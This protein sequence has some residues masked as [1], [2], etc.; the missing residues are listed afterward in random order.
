MRREVRLG[1]MLLALAAGLMLCAAFA[2]AQQGG[3]G[4]AQETLTLKAERKIEFTTDEGTWISVDVSPDGQTIVFDL[5]GDLYTLPISGG[6]AK[7]L[8]TG[9][10]FDSQPKFSPDGKWIA[11]LSDRSGGEN[12]W[13]MKADGTEP[14]QL[15]R[16][17]DSEFASPVWT[18]DGQY[19]V[20]AR[21]TWP[22]RVHELWMYHI[23]G[24][25]G[26]QLTRAT[27]AG[28]AA[29]G[30]PTPGPGGQPPRTN[31]IGA[32]FSPDGRYL[33]FSRKINGFQYNAMFPLWQIVRHD[34]VTGE[35]DTL[36][37]AE[38]SAMRPL[39]SPDGTKMV[40]ATRYETQTGLRIRDLKTGEERWLKY[41]VQRDDQESRY[42]MDLM[43]GYAFLPDGK[44]LLLTYGGKIHRLDVATGADPVIPFTAKVAQEL[45]PK[46]DF[47]YRVDQ[48]PVRARL[49]QSP[50][51]SPDGS[52]LAFS[53]LTH[54]YVMDLPANC[55][56]P[57]RGTPRR[58]TSGNAREYQPA[59]S[60]DGRWIAYVT[61]DNGQGGIWKIAADGSGAPQQLT[62]VPEFYSDP[63]WSPDGRRIV[64]M[65]MPAQARED[66][67]NVG[68]DLIWIPAEGGE[69]KVIFPS[70]G[71]AN[72][73]FTHDPER[74]YLRS[75]QGLIS[76]RWDGTER[77]THLRV[78]GTG[79]YSAD[80]PVPADGI[81]A[82]PDA[83][84]VLAHVMNQLYLVA[85]PEVGGETPTV[86]VNSPS[87]PVKKLTDVG[88]D[89]FDWADD[90]KTIT[91]AIGASFLREK[92]DS[93]SLEMPARPAG[94]EGV[95]AG[96]N[97]Q[98]PAGAPPAQRPAPVRAAAGAQEYT[99]EIEVPRKTPKGTIVLRGATVITM[100]GEEVLPDADIVVSDNRITSIGKRSTSVPA[101][102]RVFD[103]K[104][105]TI[106]PGFVDTH[107]H[108]SEIKRGVLDLQNWSFM[109]NVA[110]GV[111]TGLD[112]Q[113]GTN[114]MF[115]YQDLADTG[116]IIGLRAFSTGP[117]VFSN[118]RFQSLDEVKDVLERYKNYYHT[119]NI[120]SYIV[121][122]RKTRQWMV[123]ASKALGMMPTT[124]GA[125]DQKLDLTHFIDGMHGN[126]HTLPY[127]PLYK[128]TVQLVSQSGT[129]YTPTFI[130]QYGGPWAENYYYMYTEVHDN[131]K[132]AHFTPHTILD[133][134][135]ERRGF[136]FRPEEFAF[137]QYAAQATKILRAGGFVG[138]GS[139]GQLQGLG[140]HWEMWNLA[141]GGAT[142]MEVLRAATIQGAK[143]IGVA[144]D[145]GS[146]EPGKLADL[147]ILDKNPLDD[148]HNTNTIRWVMKNGELFE[149]DTLNQVWPEQKQ[150]PPFWWYNEK[151]SGGA[152]TIPAPEIRILKR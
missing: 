148:I 115:A 26:V 97:A 59:W 71:L 51:Q 15:S 108:W 5:L 111:T 121:G 136:W 79:S 80:Q 3:R 10:A 81:V 82:S 1:R 23:R 27:T 119:P 151:P 102:A 116:E 149:G 44:S 100:K 130:V 30:P 77:R 86:N 6:E 17:P 125:L 62:T 47:P 35:D 83:H 7:P 146:V 113:T 124:E 58:L 122:N 101:G 39:I 4:R 50:S 16:D 127:T 42:T 123:E 98:Q 110:Y 37:Q 33:Y 43:P 91:W 55:A 65:R 137:P 25:S 73:H 109:A 133:Q 60:P 11:F 129:A 105:K 139:H 52:R 132:L 93:I 84:W 96:E 61:W 131:T 24:G 28:A 12:L 54:L 78:T 32:A 45:G 69:A 14:K 19:V 142:P 118:N 144:Q 36:T 48:G 92:T 107:A 56:S 140:Y 112:V 99:A 41:P 49:I 22:L 72:P 64:A 38:G 126:E 67:S 76:V 68:Q 75:N 63:V 53:A 34:R 9:M 20:A 2:V 128:D 21:T 31:S 117:G 88:A 46:L 74:I 152:L 40:Y 89:Y 57:C 87:V 120:K 8:A 141:A 138:I 95:G 134:K 104:G 145:L 85:M 66:Y 90:G 150:L 103:V 13:I 135:T 18:P 147:V 29:A 70:R 143:I 106:V 94:G 114:D